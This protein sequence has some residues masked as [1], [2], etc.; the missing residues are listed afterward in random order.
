MK[1]KPSDIFRDTESIWVSCEVGEKSIKQVM[2]F[3]GS[4][5]IIYASDFPHEPTEDD[6]TADVPDFLAR[7]ELSQEEKGKVLYHNA[8]NFYG[9]Q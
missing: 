2:D 8:K 9:L 7:N 4:D 3:C 5:R 1:K 6:L